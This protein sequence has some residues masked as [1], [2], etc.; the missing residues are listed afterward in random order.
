M[1]LHRC[2][3]PAGAAFAFFFVSGAEA[4]NQ[5]PAAS[6]AIAPQ[7]QPAEPSTLV[8]PARVRLRMTDGSRLTGELLRVEEGQ[9]IVRTSASP[10][11]AERV[12][13][14]TDV[15]SAEVSRGK[16]PHVRR[17]AKVGA[18]VGG[19]AL[20]LAVGAASAGGCE[21]PC[22]IYL[23]A[24]GLGGAAVGALVGA[25][26]GALRKTD[27]WEDIPISSLSAASSPAADDE[28]AAPAAARQMGF[29]IAPTIDHG[30]QARFSISWR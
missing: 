3:I 23:A 9:A 16:G 5:E 11:G 15:K 19:G 1:K 25:S 6:E 8:L 4:R 21:G 10:R 12:I 22:I 17:G 26:I 2:F 18:G 20:V 30:V 13:A 29:A 7:T 14:L 27:L 28:A 24:G